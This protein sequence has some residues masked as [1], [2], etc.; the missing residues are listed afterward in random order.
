LSQAFFK[1]VYA[2]L[3][4]VLQR[5]DDAKGLLDALL[6]FLAVVLFLL[7]SFLLLEV[8]DY[9][10]SRVT[11]RLTLLGRSWLLRPSSAAAWLAPLS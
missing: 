10:V 7:D 8:E 5:A 11:A 3:I 6:S 1:D 9:L 2:V 4:E